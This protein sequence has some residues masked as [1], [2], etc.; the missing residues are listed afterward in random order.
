MENLENYSLMN[1]IKNGPDTW[2]DA[3]SLWTGRINIAKM[4]I[5]LKKM[6]RFTAIHIKISLA[7]FTE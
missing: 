1:E 6:F 5:V 4:T 7:F 2:K 3:P